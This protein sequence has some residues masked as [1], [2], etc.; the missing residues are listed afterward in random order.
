[1]DIAESICP[2][3]WRLPTS[4]SYTKNYS[5]G[6]LTNAYG[7]TNS[8]NGTDYTEILTA[9]LYFVASGRVGANG[10]QTLKRSQGN[11]WSTLA[12][13]H[14]SDAY[15]LQFNQTSLTPSS[16]TSKRNG[17]SIRCVAI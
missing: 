5:F 7:I 13:S 16:Y 3:G 8:A 15:D 6:K 9:P 12:K 17:F 4:N 14:Y 10:A 11:Y 2:A 1:M